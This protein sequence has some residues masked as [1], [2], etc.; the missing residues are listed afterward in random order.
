MVELLLVLVGIL[1]LIILILLAKIYLIRKSARE[2]EEAFADRL[3]TD[4]NTLIDISCN[5]KHMRKLANAIN[6]ELR[7][8]RMEQHRFQQGDLELKNAATN[9][10]HDLRTP[11]T[12]ICGYLDLLEQQNDSPEVERYIEIIQNRTEILK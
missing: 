11:L 4:T 5:D 9:I 10:S 12:A 7:K 2:I 1:V 6:T 3:V 8:L